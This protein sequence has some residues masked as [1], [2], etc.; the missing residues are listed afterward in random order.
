[1]VYTLHIGV[2]NRRSVGAI[3]LWHAVNFAYKHSAN[4]T[5]TAY[6]S[7]GS[8][9]TTAYSRGFCYIIV[10]MMSIFCIEASFRYICRS[11]FINSYCLFQMCVTDRMIS[12]I[13]EGD[14][15]PDI[16]TAL[17]TCLSHPPYFN[18]AELQLVVLAFSWFLE[19]EMSNLSFLCWGWQ[20]TLCQ[21][22]V[23]F[24]T[25]F[26]NI[27]CFDVLVMTCVNIFSFF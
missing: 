5:I 6:F 11:I 26:G 19:D 13:H 9:K 14:S 17:L 12:R 24:I 20:P 18:A 2:V 10:I 22:H 1:M 23:L 3:I 15:N 25:I 21:S 7:R 4:G 8:N 16:T 27:L